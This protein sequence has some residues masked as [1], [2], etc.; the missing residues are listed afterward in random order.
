MCRMLSFTDLDLWLIDGWLLWTGAAMKRWLLW[1]GGCYRQVAAI[2]RLV[3][4]MN[5]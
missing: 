1:T 5:R 4:A 3:A 2:D